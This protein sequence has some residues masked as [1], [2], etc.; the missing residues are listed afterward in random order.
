LRENINYLEKAKILYTSGFF[1]TS[2]YEALLEVA[3]YAAEHN[4]PLGFNLSACFLIQYN[5]KEVNSV[6]DYADFI[7]CN[8]DEAKCFGETNKIEG[9]ESLKDVAVALARWNKINTKRN[10]TVIIT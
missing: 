1:V 2:N 7:F 10:R 4:K 9:V 3:R 6:L 5:T 8:E